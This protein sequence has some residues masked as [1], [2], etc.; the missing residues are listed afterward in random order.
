VNDRPHP[1][2]AALD[3]LSRLPR[4]LRAALKRSEPF[5][6]Q[7]RSELLRRTPRAPIRAG[8][9][10]SP[11]QRPQ[12]RSRPPPRTTV[13]S[14]PAFIGIT[15]HRAPRQVWVAPLPDPHEPRPPPAVRSWPSRRYV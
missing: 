14:K 11:P 7:P 3:A 1:T 15:P 13:T 8:P 9:P 5:E 6:H 10:R 12:H 4:F 2:D